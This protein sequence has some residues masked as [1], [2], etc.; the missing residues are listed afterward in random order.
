VS[1]YK[2]RLECADADLKAALD[3]ISALSVGLASAEERMAAL[4]EESA[5]KLREARV[6][7]VQQLHT[8]LKT[9]RAAADSYCTASASNARR[10]K[11]CRCRLECRCP[12]RRGVDLWCAPVA[13]PSRTFCPRQR[14]RRPPQPAPVTSPFSSCCMPCSDAALSKF[15]ETSI[16]HS[17]STI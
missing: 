13:V 9:S 4:D 7:Q 10:L 12:R 5:R 3:A 2:K 8:K 11:V 17:L 6:E 15:P 16:L 14:R 1:E